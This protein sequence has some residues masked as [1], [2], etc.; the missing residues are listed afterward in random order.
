MFRICGR[1]IGAMRNMVASEYILVSIL[2]QENPIIAKSVRGKAEK[3]TCDLR[4]RILCMMKT[5]WGLLYFSLKEETSSWT[6]NAANRLPEIH[7]EN[8]FR[9]CAELHIPHRT[10][11]GRE[12]HAISAP[13]CLFKGDSRHFT[14]AM[15]SAR[16]RL[17]ESAAP[18]DVHRIF[19]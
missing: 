10:C 16:T 1:K 18:F 8:I 14:M 13:K 6:T 12:I 15:P 19:F 2:F 9:T 11:I 7:I 4:E 3:T 17:D 5:N